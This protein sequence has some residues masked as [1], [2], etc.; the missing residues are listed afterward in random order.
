MSSISQR[1]L[2]NDSAGVMRRVEAGESLT[3]TRRGVPVADLV[4]HRRSGDAASRFVAADHVVSILADT[5]EWGVEAF[6]AELS[7]LDRSVD[8]EPRDPWTRR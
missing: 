1:E 5:P 4:P 8:D 3:V 6:D 2:R 7:D